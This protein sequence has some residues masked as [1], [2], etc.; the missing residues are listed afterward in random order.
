MIFSVARII[1]FVTEAITLEPG[2]VI[3]TGTPPGVGFGRTPPRYLQPGDTVRVEIDRIGAH[4]E[5]DREP[6]TDPKPPRIPP[7]WV[8]DSFLRGRVTSSAAATGA[9]CRRPCGCSKGSFGLIETKALGAAAELEHRRRAR[10]GP[11][12]ER[13]AGR[14]RRANP[15]ALASPAPAAHLDRLLRRDGDGRWRNNATSELLAGRP[16]GVDARLGPASSAATGR[17]RSGTQLPASIRTGGSGTEA[18]F[19]TEYFDLMVQRPRGRSA[20]RRGDGR[21]VAVHRAVRLR[22]LRL[23][24]RAPGCATSAAE[25]GPCSHRVLAAFPRPRRASCSTCP[26]SWP[27]RRRSSRRVA[28][29]TG[30]RWSVVTSSPVPAGCDLYL[31]QSI[32][33]DWDD[34]SAVRILT[35]VREAMTPGS[36]VLLLEVDRAD[37]PGEPPVEVRRSP[38][39]RAHRPRPRAHPSRVPRRW[40]REPALRLERVVEPAGPRRHRARRA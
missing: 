35:R 21:G 17:S 36:R 13:L 39:A 23:R 22:G 14:A 29:R 40:P 25:P 31:L 3:F 33:H 1:E 19:G 11:A 5:P 32:V 37:E 12:H 34:E 24:R 28:W 8:V 27:G 20:V 4:R 16:S 38:D 2:D 30:A 7:R 6:V 10:R 15:D 9:S 26:R 18:A